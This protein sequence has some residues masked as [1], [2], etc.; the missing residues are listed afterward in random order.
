[1]PPPTA[2]TAQPM[3]AP[4]QLSPM[5]VAAQPL[6]TPA[7]SVPVAP[8]SAPHHPTPFTRQA[9][10]DVPTGYLTEPPVAAP[11]YALPRTGPSRAAKLGA[12]C[13]A[14]SL[15]LSLGIGVL[16]LLPRHGSLRVELETTRRSAAEKAEV[17]ID[18]QKVCDVAP[19]IVADL[20]P[21]LKTIRVIGPGIP[22]GSA[23]VTASVEAGRERLAM[24]PIG[25]EAA[26]ATPVGGAGELHVSSVHPGVR[27]LVDGV[28]HGMLPLDMRDVPA[29]AHRIRFEGGERYA[30]LERQVEVGA[31]RSVDLGSI[32]LKLLKGRIT[33]DDAPAGARVVLVRNT[34]PSSE[35]V[36]AGPWPMTFE[37]DA[38]SWQ[39]IASKKGQGE[40]TEEVSFEDGQVDKKVRLELS[41]NSSASA[42]ASAPMAVA[43][44]D[45]GPT[46]T[47]PRPGPR[48]APAPAPAPSPRAAAEPDRPAVASSSGTGTLS[49]NSL[50][51]SKVLIDG[52][53]LGSTPKVDVPVP[54]GT[55]TVTFVHPDLGKKSVT[56]TIRAGESASA[57]V[58]FRKD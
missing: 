40:V 11:S 20:T 14:A 41:G 53:P 4:V 52:R 58:R 44:R 39:I 46:R 17:F 5:P 35:R 25:N 15:V 31:G 43:A 19:C 34:P 55:H 57:S 49:M 13:G 27:V 7:P 22:G 21:G 26:P 2:Y 51:L 38:V 54:A 8:V 29:G 10:S 24:V 9:M 56:V 50:P 33:V 37:V 16:S 32:R 36:L 23:V 45:P 1:M 42:P 28:D 3:P 48:E 18:G 30:T 12:I 6:P 47:P